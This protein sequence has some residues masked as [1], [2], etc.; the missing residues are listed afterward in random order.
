V[1]SPTNGQQKSEEA[2]LPHE[3]LIWPDNVC[4]ILLG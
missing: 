3:T 1:Q 4:V 2:V